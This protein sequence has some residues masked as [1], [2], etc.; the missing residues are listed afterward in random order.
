MELILEPLL[1]NKELNL[2]KLV[3]LM[4]LVYYGIEQTKLGLTS[5]KQYVVTFD[6]LSGTTGGTTHEV[7]EQDICNCK[8]YHPIHIFKTATSSSNSLR[9]GVI[10]AWIF[11]H[12]LL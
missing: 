8:S 9:F 2:P 11:S 10:T 5:G 3:I 4:V 6:I 7:A 12:C 1:G